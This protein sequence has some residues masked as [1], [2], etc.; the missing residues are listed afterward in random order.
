LFPTTVIV[1]P[2][3]VPV[4]TAPVLLSLKRNVFVVNAVQVPLNDDVGQ[5]N[6]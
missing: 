5:P 6:D 3:Y 4:E 2:A 1:P